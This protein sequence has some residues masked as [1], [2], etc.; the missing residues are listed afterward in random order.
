LRIALSVTFVEQIV[1]GDEC[2]PV[3]HNRLIG[4]VGPN[5]IDHRALPILTPLAT[6]CSVSLED[7][8]GCARSEPMTPIPET[9]LAL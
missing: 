6:G 4:K 2:R 9:Q 3:W 8:I 5:M 1:I 7:P